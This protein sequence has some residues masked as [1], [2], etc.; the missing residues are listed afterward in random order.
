[1]QH[2]TGK[3]PCQTN[4]GKIIEYMYVN[5]YSHICVGLSPR[6]RLRTGRKMMIFYKSRPPQDGRSG[7][8][9]N[10]TH[11]QAAVDRDV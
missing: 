4:F 7:N 5:A 9:V 11:E 3:V 6:F 8:S 2:R 1:M 10:L